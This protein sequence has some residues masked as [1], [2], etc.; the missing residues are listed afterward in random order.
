MRNPALTLNAIWFAPASRT[1]KAGASAPTSRAALLPEPSE[2]RPLPA[3]GLPEESDLI[4]RLASGDTE[5]LAELM[6]V[7]SEGL[8]RYA[9]RVT[10]SREAAQDTVQDVFIKVWESRAE[11]APAG[12]LGGYLL[13]MVRNR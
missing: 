5:A 6:R 4:A 3:R 13:R 2:A 9:H 12:S 8:I 10:G 11:F 7:H 1:E